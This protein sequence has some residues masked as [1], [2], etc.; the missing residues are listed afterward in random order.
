MRSAPGI[1]VALAGVSFVLACGVASSAPLVVSDEACARAPVD[2][3]GFA[4]CVDGRVAAPQ[5][6]V[7][8]DRVPAAKRSRNGRYLFATEAYVAKRTHP[9]TTFLV[10]VRSADEVAIAGEISLA[11]ASLPYSGNDAAFA[12]AVLAEKLAGR[13]GD[14]ATVVLICRNGVL[15]ARASN[16]LGELGAYA[17]VDGVE[18]DPDSGAPPHENGWKNAGLPWQPFRRAGR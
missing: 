14:D 10:D 6:S 13:F 15:A 8:P 16:A 1:R 12:R 11:D 4:T 3:S 5:E 18:G 17:V 2:V 9:D 7:D